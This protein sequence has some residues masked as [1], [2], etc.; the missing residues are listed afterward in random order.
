MYCIVWFPA[1]SQADFDMFSSH[2]QLER[3]F[4]LTCHLLAGVQKCAV[5]ACEFQSTD[6]STEEEQEEAEQEP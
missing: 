5:C 6:H 4:P 1:K 2:Q 3:Y